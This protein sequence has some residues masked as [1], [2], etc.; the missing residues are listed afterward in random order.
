MFLI[1][2]LRRVDWAMF[3]CM[4]ALISAVMR[5]K[6]TKF[7]TNVLLLSAQ[8]NYITNVGCHAHC[9]RKSVIQFLASISQRLKK[10]TT[11]LTDF[12][13]QWLKYLRL[14]QISI[15]SNNKHWSYS[16]KNEHNKKEW[17][18]HLICCSCAV[19]KGIPLS[20]S[21]YCCSHFGCR[22]FSYLGR[23]NLPGRT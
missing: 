6:E 1:S 19:K 22:F 17:K 18:Q 13:L 9:P 2:I 16:R 23:G 3:V 10:N 5:A 4:N 21:L 7:G 12:M 11:W 20:N 14:L 15:Q 8:I